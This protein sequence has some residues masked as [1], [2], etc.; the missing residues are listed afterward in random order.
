MKTVTLIALLLPLG[1]ALAA[2]S[3]RPEAPM[4]PSPETRL[5]AGYVQVQI[6]QPA[7]VWVLTT[8]YYCREQPDVTCPPGHNVAE[9]SASDDTDVYDSKQQCEARAAIEQESFTRL[10][11]D[12]A[13]HAKYFPA[14]SLTAAR[15]LGLVRLATDQKE[16]V[17]PSAL[18]SWRHP[19][20]TCERYTVIVAP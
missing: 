13:R 2:C 5:A 18:L 20:I 7:D 10:D 3:K 8:T 4:Q 1:G 19:R 12:L 11:D 17:H 9:R 14:N 15:N 16:Y 6:G